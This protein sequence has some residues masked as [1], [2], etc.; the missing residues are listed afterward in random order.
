[1]VEHARTLAFGRSLDDRESLAPGSQT[2]SELRTPLKP[3]EWKLGGLLRLSGRS[4][5]GKLDE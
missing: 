3:T 2:F 1:M 5:P 4:I